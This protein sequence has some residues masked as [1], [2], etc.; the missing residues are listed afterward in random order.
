MGEKHIAKLCACDRNLL[1]VAA[2]QVAFSRNGKG[3]QEI[4]QKV[5][6]KLSLRCNRELIRLQRSSL[7]AG[8]VEEESGQAATCMHSLRE[9]YDPH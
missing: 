5:G 8:F 7:A 3:V 6:D 4:V 1:E 2:L 9:Y